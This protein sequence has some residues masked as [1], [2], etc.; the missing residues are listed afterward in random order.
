MVGLVGLRA[1]PVFAVVVVLAVLYVLI[2]PLPE[3]AA[4]NSVRSLTFLVPSI[5]SLLAGALAPFLPFLSRQQIVVGSGLSRSF[6]CSRL[7]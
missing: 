7:C 5:F 2:S 4:T 1:K 6:L 3:M